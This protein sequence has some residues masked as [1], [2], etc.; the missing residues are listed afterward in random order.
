MA[1]TNTYSEHW[2]TGPQSTKFYVRTYPAQSQSEPT[3]PAATTAPSTTTTTSA[4]APKGILVFLH[5]FIEHIGRY[6]HV[7]PHWSSRG[8]HVFAFDQRG[9]G[10]TASHPTNKS[11]DS[12]YAK[13]SGEHQ[14]EDAEWAVKTA[15]EHFSS[16]GR[17]EE[18][19]VFV[20]G[21]S[22]V[23]TQ[24]GEGEWGCKKLDCIPQFILYQPLFI[25][26]YPF[27]PSPP[28]PFSSLSI[29][30]EGKK[31][32]KVLTNHNSLGRR[33]RTRLR[34][35]NKVPNRR[36]NCFL[37]L[38]SPNNSR[39]QNSALGRRESQSLDAVLDYPCSSESRG[40]WH[41]ISFSPA[42]FEID[43][44]FIP[45]RCVCMCIYVCVS[46]TA[47]LERR[48]EQPIVFEGST[49]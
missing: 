21:H 6:S 38:N 31:N 42:F 33:S 35:E 8:F 26:S 7:F 23:S 39:T 18:L 46:P 20:M 14:L 4:T 25:L 30:K 9:F 29:K 49:D 41:V 13:T 34:N 3:S 12:S 27:A 11:P 28:H 32:N 24:V 40:M 48:R 19:P 43:I 47:P 5:G 16:E 36:Y 17:G 37:P 2:L 10:Q 1:S 15:K 44:R 45:F 22:M